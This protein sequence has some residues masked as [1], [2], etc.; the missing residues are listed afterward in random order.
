MASGARVLQLTL[1]L[2]LALALTGCGKFREISTCRAL[3]RETNPTLDQ[4][5]ALN[6]KPA[7]DQQARAEQQARMAKLY[8]DLA[9]RLEPHTTGPGPLAAA[10]KDYAGLVEATGTTLKN[11]SEATRNGT[12][13]RTHEL[14]RELDRLVKRERA[15]LTRL[16]S[17][18]HG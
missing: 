18:C 11:H 1:L 4:I 5:D 16:E 2:L 9:K 15:T 8:A 3:A 14:R 10:I 13:G 7:A 17:E 12:T 6:K